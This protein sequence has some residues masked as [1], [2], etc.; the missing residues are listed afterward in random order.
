MTLNFLYLSFFN[1]Y[2]SPLW[3]TDAIVFA[4]LNIHSVPIMHPHFKYVWN[5][6]LPGREKS[7][8]LKNLGVVLPDRKVSRVEGSLAPNRDSLEEPTFHKFPYKTWR[9]VYLR[10]KVGLARRVAK[11]PFCHGRVT[12]LARP[13]FLYINTEDRPSPESTLDCSQSPIFSWDRLDIPR[14]T[15]TGTSIF[16]CTEGAGVGDYPPPPPK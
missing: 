16:K 4:K 3:R 6:K 9:P 10:N 2:S 1:F 13:T 7:V 15:V 8:W 14:V 11:S 5:I 12:L